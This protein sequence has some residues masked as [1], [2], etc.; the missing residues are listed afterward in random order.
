MPPAVE[1]QRV[2][3]W[4][5]REVS[6]VL[7]C[8]LICVKEPVICCWAAIRKDFSLSAWGY[9]QQTSPATEDL[10]RLLLL[11]E[12]RGVHTRLLCPWDSP[13]KNTGV[14]CHFLLQGIFL[15]QGS[16]PSLLHLLHAQADSLPL[17][18]PGKPEGCQGQDILAQ[19]GLSVASE[20]P[21]DCL[22]RLPIIVQFCSLPSSASI[23]FRSADL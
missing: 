14:G 4:T 2:N 16:N 12:L 15:T 7:N 13:G 3:H 17:V 11:C 8:R 18:P 19:V 1:V 9:R 21:P 23:L 10:L 6:R 20:L 5:T 22:A